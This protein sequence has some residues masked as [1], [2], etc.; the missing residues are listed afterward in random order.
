MA[1]PE[2]SKRGEDGASATYQQEP[3]LVQVC[4]VCI[5]TVVLGCSQPSSPH[6]AQTARKQTKTVLCSTL[7]KHEGAGIRVHG[8]WNKAEAGGQGG[9]VWQTL[10]LPRDTHIM[11]EFL[12]E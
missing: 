5:R 8:C 3:S 11:Q 6:P 4:Y 10:V 1:S 2:N 12:C 9:A 7:N